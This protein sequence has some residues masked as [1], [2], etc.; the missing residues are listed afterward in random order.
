MSRTPVLQGEMGQ[1]HRETEKQADSLVTMKY[2]SVLFPH[3]SWLLPSQTAPQYL[4]Q[5]SHKPTCPLS[6]APLG[7]WVSPAAGATEAA[8]TAESI[9]P[10]PRMP[11]T[12]GPKTKDCPHRR[13][14]F[15]GKPICHGSAQK[16]VSEACFV[17]LTL[18]TVA[19]ILCSPTRDIEII[20]VTQSL[21][22]S[23][24]A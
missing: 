9:C 5:W 10:G 12:R 8:S 22:Y 2:F 1:R 17:L 6:P 20:I 14:P 24:V 4:S 15:L 19:P 18:C 13:A 3:L 7:R 11:K 16:F 21:P 23:V